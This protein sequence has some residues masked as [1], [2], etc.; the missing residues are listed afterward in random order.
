[1]EMKK[2]TSK[3][4]DDNITQYVHR[5]LEDEEEFHFLRFEFLHRLNLTQYTVKLSHMKSQIQRDGK[6]EQDQLDELS[7][8]LRDYGDKKNLAQFVT[9][10]CRTLTKAYRRAKSNNW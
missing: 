9:S 7:K 6:T 10:L 5:S 4:D 8:T 1:M 3:S 2:M